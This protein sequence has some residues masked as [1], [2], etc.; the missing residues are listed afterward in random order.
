MKRS[1]LIAYLM[2]FQKEEFK[3]FEQFVASPYFNT[4]QEL[5]DFYKILQKHA[6]E[7]SEN[8]VTKTAIH[9]TLYPNKKYNEKQL[10]YLMSDLSKLIEQF[11]TIEKSKK[12][13][14]TDDAYFL[15]ALIERK[16][17]KTFQ[18]NFRKVSKDLEETTIHDA[19]FYLKEYLVRDAAVRYHLSQQSRKSNEYQQLVTNSLDNFYFVEKLQH[20]CSMLNN[21]NIIATD[22]DINYLQEI[23][24]YLGQK[25][26]INEPCVE[27][28]YLA[29]KMLG[30]EKEAA[31]FEKLKQVISTQIELL[32]PEDGRYIYHSLINYCA[33][34]FRE[35]KRNYLE[36]ALQFYLQGLEN[37]VLFEGGF[38]SPW[39][40]KNII[41]IGFSV[42]THDWVETFIHQ[43]N[44]QLPAKF[45][46]N[47]L[48]FN[49]ANLFYKKKNYDQ[50]LHHLNQTQFTDISY[51]LSSKVM[52]MKIYY[53]IKEE[54]ALLS[55]IASFSLFLKR[56]KKISKPVRQTYLN[57]CSILNKIMRKNDKKLTAIKE[58]VTTKQYLNARRWLLE[59][60]KEWEESI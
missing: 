58:E 3:L 20:S 60:I 52:L 13:A 2:T 4:K 51:N 31:H 6:P 40:Y 55:L 59:I 44:G 22:F 9:K 24:E 29:S 28:Y 23:Q 16:L 54:E 12:K 47:A 35:G 57:F 17:S 11:F 48:H 39:I 30:N 8:K 53:E 42:R 43:Y 18:Q 56:N 49:L 37:K 32:N 50:S 46:D 10:S 34:R 38:I 33:R 27:V 5:V 7:F 1:K 14:T 41:S 26:T 45:Q 21:Q 15:D 19:D 36:E 25:T